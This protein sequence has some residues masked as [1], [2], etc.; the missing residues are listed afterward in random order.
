MQEHRAS[1][2]IQVG[3]SIT[4]EQKTQGLTFNLLGLVFMDPWD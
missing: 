2:L 4:F 3:S 1:P